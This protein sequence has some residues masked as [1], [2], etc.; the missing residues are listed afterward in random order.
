MERRLAAVLIADVVGYSRLSEIDEEGTRIRFHTDLHE[1]FEPKIATHHGRLIKTMGDGILVEFHSVVDALRCAV[2]IQQQKAERN[3]ALRP[4]QRMLFRIGV[5]LGDVIVEGEDIH[6]DGVNI[7][8]RLESLAQPGGICISGTAFDH[9]VHKAEV[10]FS[11]LGEQQ[12]KNIADPVRVY[13]VLLDPSE[14]GKVVASRR[15]RRRAIILATLAALLIAAAAIVFAWQWPFAPQRPSVAVLPFANLSSD[16]G[17]DYFTDGITDSL[18]ADLTMLSDLDV[19]G[20]NS[21]FAYK[22]KPLVLADIGRDLG[23]RFIVEGSVQRIGDQ[24]RVNAQLSDAAS[25]DHLWANRFNRSAA[26]VMAVQ[27]ELSRQIA[28]ALGLKLTQSETER[29]THP[30]TANLEAYDYYLRAEQATRTGRR[31]RL[32]EALALFD[33][34]EALDPGFAEAFAADA[35][36]T[37]YV[38]RSAYDDVLQSAL[39]RKRAYEKASRALA[40]DSALSSPYAV[41]A[42]MQVVDR[43]YEQA[44]TSAQQAVSLG[45]ADAEAHMAL[46][47]VQLFSGSHAEAGAAVDTA[48]R[49]DPNLSAINR[50]TAGLVFYLQRDYTKAIDSFERARDG[51][52]GN[53][54]FVTPLA[55]AYVRAGRLDDARATVAEGLRLLAGRD[56]LADWR[57]SNAHFRNE[58]DLA[59]ILDALREAGLP[60]WPFGFKG[61]EHERLH[62]EE[63][64]SIVMGKLLR[65]KT[66]PSGSAALMQIER[67]GKAAFRSTTQM[68]T[69][70]VFVN[71]DMLCEQSENAFGRADCGPIYRPANSPAETSYA[72]VNSTKVFYFSPVK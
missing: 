38:W 45:S 2:K 65:G 25:G 60:E 56:S 23:V 7:A 36:A 61:N 15:P 27:D 19:I 35:H 64:A 68:V 70:T 12:L 39:A 13:R 50:Y 17:Q 18:I 33:K 37:A 67:D 22:G 16:A 62:G 48:L 43:R 28:E 31:S 69:G 6:G 54:D 42:V 32:L 49:H 30:P 40:L 55:M 44:V 63:I 14:A 34:A 71:G 29:I 41:L 46:A 3:A 66:E 72:Y 51:S 53:G 5:N 9:T 1:L 26:D 59:F 8:A 4:E 10:G 58:Q 52:P 21:V 47:Y 24:I 20:H 11:C 57:L